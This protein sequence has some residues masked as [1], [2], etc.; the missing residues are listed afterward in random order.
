MIKP[1]AVYRRP[2]LDPMTNSLKVKDWK[3]MF[4]ANTNQERGGESTLMQDKIDFVSWYKRQKRTL[5]MKKSQFIKIYNNYKNIHTKQQSPKY[6]IQTL[7]QLKG[8]QD[9]S[10]VIVG[11]FNTS[12]ST[13][14][15]KPRHKIKKKIKDF[16]STTAKLI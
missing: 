16:K 9:N 7:T 14:D 15:R 10:I 3:M 13:L 5:D 12:H 11:D 2:T 8:G 6:M 4:H 1:Y